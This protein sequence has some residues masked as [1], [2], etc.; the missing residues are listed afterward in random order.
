MSIHS[1]ED[2]NTTANAFSVKISRDEPVSELKKAIK[3]EKALK[4][5]HFLADKLKLWK[6]S[7]PGDHLDDQLKNLKLNDSDE[8]SA[9]KKISKYL[10]DSP[11]EEH[12]HVLVEPPS[13][14]P[15]RAANRN[16]LIASQCWRNRSATFDIVVSPKRTKGFKWTVDIDNATL[17]GLKEYIREMEK[18]P[19]L[20]NDGAV[21]NFIRDI[22]LGTIK[23]SAKCSGYSYQTTASSL[24]YSLRLPR[25]PSTN[26]PFRNA[27]T[28]NEKYKEALRKLF[29]E[30]ETRVAT[31]PIDVSY[32]ATKSRIYSYTYLVSATYPFKDQVKVVPEKLI[33]GKNGRGNLKAKILEKL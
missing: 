26:G 32:E 7:I 17:D 22:H 18:P 6:V 16:Y 2:G 10:P 23:T 4:F 27:N 15:L 13:R 11:A 14:L 1:S 25:S 24:L 9:I 29:D 3:A 8:L 20:E 21:L 19:T 30:L 33:E 5:D 28:E 31:T 12:I